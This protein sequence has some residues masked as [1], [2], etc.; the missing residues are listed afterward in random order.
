MQSGEELRDKRIK[1]LIPSKSFD[2]ICGR[3]RWLTC[4]A[5]GQ[6]SIVGANGLFL[7]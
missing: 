5:R 3:Q 6:F 2:S 4:V 1:V 7:M